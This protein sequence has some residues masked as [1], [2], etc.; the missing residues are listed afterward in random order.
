MENVKY[1]IISVVYVNLHIIKCV[2]IKCNINILC[3]N[4]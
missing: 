2:N 3:T 4:T 1:Y